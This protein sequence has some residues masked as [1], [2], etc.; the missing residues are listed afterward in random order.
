ME[1]PIDAKHG[2]THFTYDFPPGT[3]IVAEDGHEEGIRYE[4]STLAHIRQLI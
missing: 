1:G 2:V 3:E 4:T